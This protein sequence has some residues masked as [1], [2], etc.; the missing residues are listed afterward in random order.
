M[1]YHV[2]WDISYRYP[3][4]AIGVVAVVCA[5]AALALAVNP[6]WRP[7]L[8]RMSGL[9]LAAAGLLFAAF[10]LHNIGLPDGLLLAA[11]AVPALIVAVPAAMDLELP[12]RTAYGNPIPARTAA[13]LLLFIY[14]VVTGLT[15]CQQL[16]SLDLAYQLDSGRATVVAG[17]VQ[18]FTASQHGAN[19]AKGPEC[20]TVTGHRYC[21]DW[22]PITVGFNWTNTEGGPIRNGL[23]VRVSS[24]GDLIVR[25]EIADGQ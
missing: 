21:Y 13:P 7:I 3:E 20:F 22:N 9:W 14:L 15:G 17:T 6:R 1:S 11:C 12:T 5:L 18:D 16:A 24:I 10:G 25:L 8:R 4:A 2:A 19:S 23:H